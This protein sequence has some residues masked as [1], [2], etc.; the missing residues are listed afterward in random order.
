MASTDNRLKKG[1]TLS[2]EGKVVEVEITSV[3][4][5]DKED[6]KKQL[7]TPVKVTEENAQF[8]ENTTVKSINIEKSI[9]DAL[10]NFS[11]SIVDKV[12]GLV[13]NVKNIGTQL[14]DTS[15]TPNASASSNLTIMGSS[16]LPNS[17]TQDEVTAATPE[18]YGI[19]I[20]SSNNAS[21]VSSPNAFSGDAFGGSTTSGTTTTTTTPST[22]S[23]SSGVVSVSG[24]SDPESVTNGSSLI[25]QGI[26][27]GNSVLS[28]IKEGV[29]KIYDKSDVKG[30]SKIIAGHSIE[31]YK[32]SK[33]VNQL[34][35]PIVNWVMGLP[36]LTLNDMCLPSESFSITSSSSNLNFDVSAQLEDSF[37]ILNITPLEL[38]YNPSESDKN[39]NIRRNVINEVKYRY[40]VQTDGS[41][42][43]SHSNNYSESAFEGIFKSFAEQ[44]T[45]SNVDQF[46]KISGGMFGNS[47][48][49]N[50]LADYLNKTK[51][52]VKGMFDKAGRV[53]DNEAFEREG[54]GDISAFA[55][56][57]MKDAGALLVGGRIDLPNIWQNSS[58]PVSH[59]F[60]IELRT[61]AADPSSKAYWHD[62][63]IPLYTL[64][65]LSLP[66]GGE[67]VTYANPPYIT[68]NLD[69]S[70]M[71]VKLGGISSITWNA[72]MSDFNFLKVPRHIKVDIT[73]VDLYNILFQEESTE[74]GQSKNKNVDL[75][76]K[77]KMIERL[78]LPKGKKIA[79]EDIW[80]N[81]YGKIQSSSTKKAK[82]SNSDKANADKGVTG[83]L[84]KG[85]SEATKTIKSAVSIGGKIAE[86]SKLL[87]EAKLVLKDGITKSLDIT[88][89]D[90]LLGSFKGVSNIVSTVKSGLST[91][92][93][94]ISTGTAFMRDF[95][96]LKTNISN[97]GRNFSFNG[98]LNGGLSNSI[99][100]TLNSITRLEGNVSRL[101]NG[102]ITSSPLNLIKG[103]G[104]SINNTFSNLAS[105]IDPS[106]TVLEIADTISV[107]A[108]AISAGKSVA[109][110][111][112]RNINNMRFDSIDSA[113]RSAQSIV[114][115]ADAVL[116]YTNSIKTN[117]VDK[118]VYNAGELKA[119]KAINEEINSQAANS[120]KEIWSKDLYQSELVTA[121]DDFRT[122]KGLDSMIVSP[123]GRSARLLRSS[124]R[125]SEDEVAEEFI[126]GYGDLLNELSVA[127]EISANAVINN[128]NTSNSVTIEF[129]KA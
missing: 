85:L 18:G 128:S 29:A 74:A 52:G 73:I 75:M 30:K 84:S 50:T 63:I 82:G 3:T 114:N 1:I 59:S 101:S 83:K 95:R 5:K 32:A 66:M 58:T 79:N 104:S 10:E 39:K 67:N 69:N 124:P 126:N 127:T 43:Y 28:S 116:N 99:T 96:N 122:S 6:A 117:L 49:M 92:R 121:Y 120:M 93:N 54:F 44:N 81:E 80:K 107:T 72:P 15:D 46:L 70:Y 48:G 27:A 105:K 12:T 53:L 86:G 21:V 22:G 56:A 25:Q 47:G 110:N 113:V 108:S 23:T 119:N 42:S 78:I 45:I 57:V 62:I 88:S 102:T 100:N 111:V 13:D 123:S 98:I 11:G 64:L 7:E 112:I 37:P 125:I 17:I 26:D 40:A 109:N 68:C 35:F 89:G 34:E 33:V 19:K 129:T 87:K 60:S 94:I 14:F 76:T 8:N 31:Y 61:M 71:E 4:S 36:P 24:G 38:S 115:S 103:I 16:A 51:A 91:V 20:D 97:I 77:D 106:G 65:T 118:G 90:S 9:T 41:I 55:S 2:K